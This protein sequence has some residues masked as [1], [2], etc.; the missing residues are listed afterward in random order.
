[1][2]GF[3]VEADVI[4]LVRGTY[5]GMYRHRFGGYEKKREEIATKTGRRDKSAQQHGIEVC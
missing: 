4:L 2:L 1:V 5:G 3:Q